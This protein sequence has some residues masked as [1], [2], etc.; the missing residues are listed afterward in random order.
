[1]ISTPGV[2]LCTRL[3]GISSLIIRRIKN[4]QLF[5]YEVT[6]EQINN[7]NYASS[8]PDYELIIILITQ[9]QDYYRKKYNY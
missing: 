6:H 7:S 3:S 9:I 5:C 8:C 2:G 4:C 1:M